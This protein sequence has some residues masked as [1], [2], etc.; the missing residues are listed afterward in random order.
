ML[1]MRYTLS[2]CKK[3]TNADLNCQIYKY[4]KV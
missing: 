4:A 3:Y 2:I 1:N